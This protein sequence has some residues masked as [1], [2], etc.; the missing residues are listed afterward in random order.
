VRR[1]ERLVALEHRLPAVLRGDDKPNDAAEGIGFAN[2][3]YNMK[4]FGPSARLYAESLRADPK[5]AGDL[6]SGHR[7]NAACAAALAGA[8][9]GD[10]K[11]PL[12]EKEKTRWRKQALDWLRAD[13]AFWTRQAKTGK[14]EAKA[15][16]S[17][18]LQHWK[19]NT[20][21][22][23]IRDETAL[24]ALPDEEQKA[25]RALWAEVDALLAKAR[26]G[27]ASRPHR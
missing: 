10:D 18:Q 13:L 22:A 2:L 17:Q 21:L 6:S 4:Q 27:T 15:L 9:Q 26:A 14:P 11:P 19:A 3:A 8:G 24:K 20:D 12:D 16:V 23:G 1:A 25:C 5:L 7:Y